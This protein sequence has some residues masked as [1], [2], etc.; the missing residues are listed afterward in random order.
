[1]PVRGRLAALALVVAVGAVDLLVRASLGHGGG[2]THPTAAVLPPVGPPAVTAP[3]TLP[4][5]KRHPRPRPTARVVTGDAGRNVHGIVV[6]AANN[7]LAGVHIA[8]DESLP[9]APGFRP[10]AIT[11]DAGRFAVP[12]ESRDIAPSRPP[13]LF[14]SYD[15]ASGLVDPRAP[16]VAWVEIAQQCQRSG[17]LG[18]R[19]TMT[20]G[21]A[22]V[23]TLYQH[24]APAQTAGVRVGVECD[25]MARGNV[26]AFYAQVSAA[27]DPRDGTF[28][29]DGLRSDRCAVGV[30]DP[31]KNAGREVVLQ[32]ELAEGRTTHYDVHD[33]GQDHFPGK[34]GSHPSSS[35]T[36]VPTSTCLAVCPRRDV[37]DRP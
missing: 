20:P 25:D 30:F 5:A 36:P 17:S 3:S 31:G 1:M 19:V 16:N 12:C 13:L 23:G 11:D 22:L 7:R 24:D 15:G 32:V 28:R 37:P 29:I 9:D 6:D 34:P 14:S 27:V 33:D 10:V 2:G 21:A 8:Y 4:T 18:V 26:D 35:P